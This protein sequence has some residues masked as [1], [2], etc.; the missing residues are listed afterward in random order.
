[1][2]LKVIC[3]L[4]MKKMINPYNRNLDSK[5]QAK[6]ECMIKNKIN[7]LKYDDIKSYLEYISI[8]YGNNYLKT[9]KIK[10]NKNELC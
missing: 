3:F 6:Y 8:K 5:M 10:D 9:F 4:K 2:K 7:I 1:M